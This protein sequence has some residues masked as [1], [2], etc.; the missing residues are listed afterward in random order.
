MGIMHWY[1][2]RGNFSCGWDDGRKQRMRSRHTRR[3]SDRLTCFSKLF[4]KRESMFIKNNIFGYNHFSIWT[5][6]LIS[7]VFKS[8]SNECAF[9][10]LKVKFRL[11]KIHK[12][13]EATATK[14]SK[15]VIYLEKTFSMSGAIKCWCR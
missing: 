13:W 8:V 5:Q 9:S 15:D 1:R 4:G 3:N 11:R 12:V 6:A 10:G 7:F 14:D 2:L